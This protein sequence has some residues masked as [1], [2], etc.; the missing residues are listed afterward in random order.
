MRWEIRMDV[1]SKLEAKC[2]PDDP[3]LHAIAVL[4]GRRF[5]APGR[6]LVVGCGD[7]TEAAVLADLVRATVVGIDIANHFNPS[8]RD[9]VDLRVA[10][11]MEL[12]FE[13][14]SFDLV[15][16]Y[17][18]LE[19]VSVPDRALAEMRRVVRVT[20]SFWIGTPNRNRLVGYIGSRDA[21]RREKLA[22]NVSDWRARMAGRFRNDLGAHA[23]FTRAELRTMLGTF[24]GVVEDQTSEYYALLYARHRRVLGVLEA[25]G[26]ARFAYPAIYFAGRP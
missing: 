19:H 15:F 26:L 18:A 5:E 12:P 8:V 6:V 14:S 3:K 17:H 16:S 21:S 23:G 1:R 7:G 2:K 11:A 10:D 25:S 22:W 9:K 20:G 24:F 13:D 4:L